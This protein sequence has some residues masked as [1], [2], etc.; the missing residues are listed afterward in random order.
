MSR[1]SQQ[2][3]VPLLVSVLHLVR[4]HYAD[5]PYLDQATYMSGRVH[6]HENVKWIAVIGQSRRDKA[7]NKKGTSC[8]PVTGH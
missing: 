2:P 3:V 1:D 5:E 8:L 4:G 6:E 7:R